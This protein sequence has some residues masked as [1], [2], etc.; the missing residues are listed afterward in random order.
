MI[1]KRPLKPPVKKCPVLLSHP[2]CFSHNFNRRSNRNLKHRT[3]L[4]CMRR[5]LTS[6]AG[7][8]TKRD[9]FPAAQRLSSTMRG[10]RQSG[11][12]PRST[13]YFSFIPFGC[14]PPLPPPAAG[15]LESEVDPILR[16]GKRRN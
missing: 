10:T 7:L 15:E 9:A 14:A 11:P 3:V 4:C 16:T 6:G 12:L 5:E 2:P 8:S 1:E 13:F